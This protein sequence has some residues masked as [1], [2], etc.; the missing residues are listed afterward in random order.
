MTADYLENTNWGDD[1]PS[2]FLMTIIG[3][4]RG[5]F[6]ITNGYGTEKAT[7][8]MQVSVDHFG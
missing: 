5:E 8:I 3:T 2:V 7:P 6:Q 4:M 1:D